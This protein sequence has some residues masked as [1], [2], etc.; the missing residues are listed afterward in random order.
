L[1]AVTVLAQDSPESSEPASV[2]DGSADY[3]DEEVPE[4]EAAAEEEADEDE[5]EYETDVNGLISV[6]KRF[7]FELS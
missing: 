5:E 3:Y 1:L 4:E 6:H 2:D 7:Y